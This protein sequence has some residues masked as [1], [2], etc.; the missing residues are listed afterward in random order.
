MQIGL[1][2]N[3]LRYFPKPP[4]LASVIATTN[5][6]EVFEKTTALFEM[7]IAFIDN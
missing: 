7:A 3:K 2:I 1:N 5:I 4:H 6:V